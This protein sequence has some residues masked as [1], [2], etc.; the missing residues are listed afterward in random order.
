MNFD[1]ELKTLKDQIKFG[2]RFEVK[3]HENIVIAGM[4]GSGI[5][6]KILSEFYS[7]K[8]LFVVDDYNI[9]DFVDEKTEFFAVSYSGNTEETLHAANQAKKKGAHVHAITSGGSLSKMNYDTILIPSGLQPR[10]AL[11]YLLMPLVNR[12]LIKTRHIIS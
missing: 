10:S 5:S 9:P 8:P 3:D 11:G 2:G 4:G 12:T 7:K 6:G 1:E